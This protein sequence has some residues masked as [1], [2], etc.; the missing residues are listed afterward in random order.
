M[1]ISYLVPYK[2]FTHLD[3]CF[4]ASAVSL[5]YEKV[6]EVLAKY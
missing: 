3:F 1:A 6:F 2:K 5:V 4:A